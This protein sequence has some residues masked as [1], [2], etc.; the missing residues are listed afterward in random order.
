M[1]R[2]LWQSLS[3]VLDRVLDL[4]ACARTEFLR[5]LQSSD[6]PL[7]ASLEALLAD[8]LGVL[9]S[10]FLETPAVTASDLAPSL[11]GQT[12]GAYTLERPLGVGGMGAVWLARRSDGRF[13]GR[14]ALKLV[15]LAV[16]DPV[17][18]ER[19]AREGTVL[20]RL[21]HPN[22]GRLFDAGVTAAGQPYL[23]LEYVDGMWIDEYADAHRLAVGARLELFAQTAD[24]VA[25]AHANLIVHRDLKPSNILV[26]AAGRVKLLDFGIAKLIEED[27]TRRVEARTVTALALTP[28]YAA[29]EQVS[30]GTV[31]TATDVYALGVLLYELLAGRH[32]TSRDEETPA[33]RVH[34]LVAREPRRLS[35][36]VRRRGPGDT[37][38][39]RHAA[40][41]ST[42]VDRLQRACRGDLD[43]ILTK[44]LK[45]SPAE[46]Y[47]TVTA[48]GD[49][50]RRH[51][52][53]EPVAAR[54]DSLSY[55]A[56]RFVARH[57]L[58]LLAAS[59][60][61]VALVAGATMAVVQARESAR[62][63][64]QA[65][66]QL[67]RAEATNDLS[68]LLLS[69]ARPSG[70]SLSNAEMLA[71]GERV[72]AKRF[73][74]DAPLRVFMLLTLADRYFDNQQY[75]ARDRLVKQAYADARTIPD[76]GL[77]AYAT[78][79]WASDL[80]EHGEFR[81]AF[82]LFDEV[83][84]VLARSPEYTEFEANC[85]LFE[86]IAGNQGNDGVRA[87]RAGER[88]VALEEQRRIPGGEYEALSALATSYRIGHRYDDSIATFKRAYA[89]SESSGSARGS[90]VALLGNWSGTLQETGQMLEAA[91]IA[92]RAVRMAR[93]EDSEYGASLGLLST[94]G[95][96]LTAVGKYD[97]AARIIDEAL[98]KART[99]GSPRRH[100]QTLA[101]AFVLAAESGDV[102]R[103]S[104]L[105]QE[106]QAVLAA[107]KSATAYSKGLVDVGTARV[108]LASGELSRAVT[109][110]ARGVAT[111][112][113]ATPAQTG[114]VL[115]RL[116]LAH[117]LNAAGRFDEA[118]TAG[119]QS[120]QLLDKRLPGVTHSYQMGQALLEIASAKAGLGDRTAARTVLASA[121]EHL[122]ATAGPD[123]RA[124]ERAVGLRRALDAR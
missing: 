108:A 21:A 49:D 74:N 102:T 87:I 16:L 3:P 14:V 43:I 59:T 90:L 86:A 60:A 95:N 99:A 96:A 10:D 13:E 113:T 123:S 92:E 57:R 33:E 80:A 52:Q 118:L 17:A 29:P 116:L 75:E 24:A 32:P 38:A 89:L 114:L 98:A 7:A 100:V 103:G 23:V 62:Q 111:L 58:G 109:L 40:A 50:V 31:T 22:I 6:P 55:R 19:F 64:D 76:A 48:F 84:P 44:A 46:R 27:A 47:V 79:Q 105:V 37:E 106:A 12:I 66:T 36:A 115:A 88:A 104:R 39:A 53:G 41:R 34:A 69:S 85:L 11:A 94:Y 63:R 122:S 91:A 20:A 119:N 67:R 51:L 117:C 4:D 28:R 77:R 25:H 1:D 54:R 78:C 35:E 120:V 2:R 71:R 72:I 8:H 107:D 65:L 30:G 18:K 82:A 45:K 97:E 110:A 112:E 81:R 5:L 93:E 26:D 56:S 68:T 101:F 83:S 9:A 70:R 73:A 61:I 121:L 15:N 42:S 124:T